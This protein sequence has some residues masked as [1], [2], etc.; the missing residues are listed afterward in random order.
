MPFPKWFFSLAAGA[1][2]IASNG[3]GSPVAEGFGAERNYATH[4][5]VD[6]GFRSTDGVLLAGT[7][8]LPHGAGPFPAVV[9]HFGSDRWT[10]SAGYNGFTRIWLDAGI[11]VLSYD[12]RGVGQS[13]GICCPFR[14]PGY[15]AL[16]ARDV[17][18]GFDLI[19]DHPL[20]DRTRI[21]LY[22]FSQGGWVVPIVPTLTPRQVAFVVIGSGPAVSL[23]QQ[24]LHADL[25]GG[26]RCQASG[27]PADA[28]ER[29]VREV[30]PSLFDPSTFL[31]ALEVP[32]FWMYADGDGLV[33]VVLSIQRL[34][35]I[36][37]AHDRDWEIQVFTGVNHVFIPD[38]G[39]CET[40]RP[41]IDW[42][43]PMLA[44]LLPRLGLPAEAA[45]D[46]PGIGSSHSEEPRSMSR[47]DRE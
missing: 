44:W 8:L 35:E 29:Q 18:A 31:A 10:R 23:G 3:C 41:T 14:E 30:G 2:T 26:S 1:A 24:L 22:G 40:G 4:R 12:K 11:A 38:G 9:C 33:P 15:F 32:G 45:I 43:R 7:L 19:A 46:W 20:I 36:R 21:G 5:E 17:L 39:I 6:V 42:P 47:V 34:T 37:A 28:V 25:T 13:G 16:L 27:L